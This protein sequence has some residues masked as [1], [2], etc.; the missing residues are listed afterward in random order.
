MLTQKQMERYTDVLWW[1]LT[2]AR[3]RAF[4]KND[5]V[6]IRYDL[7]ALS[8]AEVLYTRLLERGLHPVQRLNLTP[9]ME[10]QFFKQSSRAQ[11]I[12]ELPG[13]R[14]LYERLNG[15][16]SLLAP[17]SLTHL[18]TIDSGKIAKATVARK[19]L[20]DILDRREA[21]GAFSWTLGLF[22]TEALAEHAQLTLPVYVHQ[23]VAACFL[24]KKAPIDAW[25][26]IFAHAA[27]IK[28]WLNSLKVKSYR[29][30]SERVDLEITP[31]EMRKWI[32]VSGHNI[33]SFEVFLSPDWRG[34]RGHYFADQPSFRN[35]NAVEDVCLEFEKGSA[36]RV[37]AAV[38]EDFVKKQLTM[39]KGACRLGEFSLT[40]RRFSKITRFM[41][42]TLYD[43]NFGGRYGNCHLALGAS[44]ADTFA[45][46]P[47]TLTRE[48]KDRL[49]FND[50][51]LHWD[52]VNTEKKRVTARLATGAVTTIY[53]NGQFVY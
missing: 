41:A 8:L 46:D 48:H 49:G 5:L 45:G 14:E 47:K 26:Q 50:S 30:E 53:E 11:L 17:Q 13:D 44:Y 43:E 10:Y 34:T 16:I 52:L 31:G 28:K 33:P 29:I 19:R 7:P 27:T 15:S 37:K 2:T 23:I 21:E 42:N 4:K 9:P 22:P 20:R 3:S 38:G 6:I 39:D 51:A 36:V 40:D 18:G 1:G 25:Q 32:G 35:G 12:F 24:N